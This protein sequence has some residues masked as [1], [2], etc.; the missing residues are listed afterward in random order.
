[1][2]EDPAVYPY[3]MPR[4][5]KCDCIDTSNV[6]DYIGMWTLVLPALER[7]TDVSRR[8]FVQVQHMIYTQGVPQ[9][10]HDQGLVD[11]R[12]ESMFRILGLSY[13]ALNNPLN[14]QDDWPYIRFTREQ[15]QEADR[16]DDSIVM[17]LLIQM[18]QATIT[19]LSLPLEDEPNNS[20]PFRAFR[21]GWDYKPAIATPFVRMMQIGRAHV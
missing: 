21:R 3:A 2:M 11:N 13:E 7:C 8:P 10:L 1:M 20:D 9:F 12:Y 16:V 15:F 18:F 14:P 4:E 6:A 19:H 17:D 5:L